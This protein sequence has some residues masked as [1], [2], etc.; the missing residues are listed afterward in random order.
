MSSV[1]DEDAGI[2][3]LDGR[4][5]LVISYLKDIT[6]E[7]W[8][9]RSALL[10]EEKV[11]ASAL[12]EGTPEKMALDKEG[13]FKRV[14][15]EFKGDLYGNRADLPRE[16]MAPEN[17]LE[18]TDSWLPDGQQ[19]MPER[20]GSVKKSG[21]TEMLRRSKRKLKFNEIQDGATKNRRIQCQPQG[22]VTQDSC[23]ENENQNRHPST[24]QDDKNCQNKVQH[25]TQKEDRNQGCKKN[26]TKVHGTIPKA[27]TQNTSV[28]REEDVRQHQCLVEGDSVMVYQ[29]H[30]DRK[31]GRPRLVCCGRSLVVNT[32]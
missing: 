2:Y 31:E 8:N 24:T 14:S 10:S 18:F 7:L 11:E 30:H 16:G 3:M 29:A 23:Q 22:K 28:D 12:N 26:Q 21:D 9:G 17:D 20:G 1:E 27:R 6:C 4:V 5:Q 32:R 19:I 13:T 25:S 15:G